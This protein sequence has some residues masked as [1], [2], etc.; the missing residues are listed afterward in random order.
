MR[1]SWRRIDVIVPRVFWGRCVCKPI[2]GNTPYL[3]Q[4]MKSALKINLN[5][6]DLEGKILLLLV[7]WQVATKIRLGKWMILALMVNVNKTSIYV[8]TFL[9]MIRIIYIHFIFSP[10]ARLVTWCCRCSTGQRSII[11]S[12]KPRTTRN[13][14]SRITTS[15]R[16]R[17]SW[18]STTNTS[19]CTRRTKSRCTWGSRSYS[20]GGKLRHH[21]ESPTMILMV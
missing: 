19:S 21:S 17:P 10:S 14:R 15:S 13:S 11:T 8:S 1:S 7:F 20:E 3:K 2:N 5:K 4:N 18:I 12:S 9:L 16:W 6:H